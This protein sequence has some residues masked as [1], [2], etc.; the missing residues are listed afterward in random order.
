MLHLDREQVAQKRNGVVL[1]QGLLAAVVLE[2][3]VVQR[4]D[5][6]VLEM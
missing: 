2:K 5:D 4:L 6:D 1:D 3:D